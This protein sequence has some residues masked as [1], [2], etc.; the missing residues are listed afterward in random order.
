MLKWVHEERDFQKALSERDKVLRTSIIFPFSTIFV[1]TYPLRVVKS[2]EICL[3]CENK[4][5]RK[6][7]AAMAC[8]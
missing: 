3:E 4:Q 7:T 6:R 5:F 2:Q 1:K 8:K